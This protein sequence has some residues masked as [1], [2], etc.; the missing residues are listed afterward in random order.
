MPRKVA[1]AQPS[2]GNPRPSGV[3]PGRQAVPTAPLGGSWSARHAGRDGP[4]FAASYGTQPAAQRQLRPRAGGPTAAN[5][6]LLPTGDRWPGI[7]SVNRVHTHTADRCVNS[8]EPW[9]PPLGGSW[10]MGHSLPPFPR[11]WLTAARS[12]GQ[13]GS[14]LAAGHPGGLA[15]TPARTVG[16]CPRSE[17]GVGCRRGELRQLEG[18][19]AAHPERRVPPFPVVFLDPLRDTAAGVGPWSRRAPCSNSKVSVEWSEFGRRAEAQLVI[20]YR[21]YPPRPRQWRSQGPR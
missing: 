2:R 17:R 3:R 18:D 12:R 13:S 6:R 7:T 16:R 19:R 20:S 8:L 4:G 21:R 10:F 15:L 1:P 9:R 5:E 14:S 11:S